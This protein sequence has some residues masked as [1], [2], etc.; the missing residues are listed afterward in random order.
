MSATQ[1]LAQLLCDLIA[2]PSVN[3][4]QHRECSGAPY[5][6]SRVAD[7]V[8]D[9]FRPFGVRIER[10]QALPGRESVLVHLPGTDPSAKAI[11]LEAH[12]DTVGPEGMS[13]PFHPRVEDGRVYG[14]GAC[15]TKGSLAAMMFVVRELLERD[16]RLPRPYVLAATV[17][18]EFGM[19]GAR[20]LVQSGMAFAGAIVGEPT[21]LK[22]IPAHDGQMYLKISA[23][24]KAAH[25]SMPQNGVNAIYLM[26]EVINVLRRRAAV[27]YPKRVHA[28]CAFPKLTIAMI[29]GGVSEHIV[30][31]CC[32][33]A[34]DF[35]VIPGETCQGALEE[36]REWLARDLN[37]NTLR[38]ITIAEPHKAEPPMETPVHHPL[39]QGMRQAAMSVLGDAQVEGVPYNTDASHYGAAGVPCV[40]FGPGGIEQAHSALEYVEI[41]QLAAAVEILRHFLLNGAMWP[42]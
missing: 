32:E 37:A 6:E 41:G 38:R 8:E 25:T 33:I 35:R 27:E 13:L 18:E 26:A 3:P 10:Q 20:R 15:D 19:S 24:G 23:H 17:D 14:R 9:Y 12:M 11:L 21:A 28:L 5:G 40:V 31:D 7:Y 4:E 29:H 16:I 2:I 39:V 36:V 42:A 30:P 22:I 1:E 34:I